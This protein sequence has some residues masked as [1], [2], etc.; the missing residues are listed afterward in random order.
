[1]NVNKVFNTCISRSGMRKTEISTALGLR[2]NYI[3]VAIAKR[4]IQRTDTFAKIVDVCG[5]DLLVRNRTT[6]EE[7]LID[8]PG[9]E[10]DEY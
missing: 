7:M 4:T 3:S 2:K 5:W 6:G 8:P 9:T 10:E 1:M